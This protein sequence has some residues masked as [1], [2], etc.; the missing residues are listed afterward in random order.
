M[1]NYDKV[2]CEIVSEAQG[3][4][5]LLHVCCAP[6]AT[7]CLERFRHFG[8]NKSWE[9]DSMR[10]DIFFYNPNI[11]PKEE[12]FKRAAE[13]ESLQQPFGV[14]HFAECKIC[15]YDNQVFLQEAE[16][17]ENEKEG[18]V[19]CG[20]CFELRL[21]KTACQAKKQG[22]DF[23]CTSLT[24]SPHKNSILINKI[25]F[26]VERLEGIRYLPSDFKK[27]DGYRRSVELS[28]KLGLYRQNYCGCCF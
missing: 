7:Y 18:G 1:I 20:K 25:G 14:G 10:V 11:M 26:E 27:D 6:C 5:V 8:A 22:Y 23:F 9:E 3:K 21:A 2:F 19:R 17:F 24:V 4:K 12:Y 13:V 16:G 15:Q 28:K